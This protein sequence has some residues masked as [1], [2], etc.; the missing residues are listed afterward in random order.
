[1]KTR[2]KVQAEVRAALDAPNAD[3]RKIRYDYEAQAFNA[4]LNVIHGFDVDPPRSVISPAKQVQRFREAFWAM[5]MWSRPID[6]SIYHSGG[7]SWRPMDLISHLE[8]TI[9]RAQEFDLRDSFAR[10][11]RTEAVLYPIIAILAENHMADLKNGK[12]FDGAKV[13]SLLGV[14]VEDI[15]A[16]VTGKAAQ[17]KAAAPATAAA[18]TV[19]GASS[20]T[21]SAAGMFSGTA[22]AADD[23]VVRVTK[24]GLNVMAARP[25]NEPV[26]PDPSL[27][28]LAGHGNPPKPGGGH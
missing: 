11:G 7:M 15:V 12:C 5:E 26:N 24:E 18:T 2:E 8:Y 16:K 21:T 28:N 9:S 25:E 10:S 3:H 17:P 23:K 1:M 22:K 13:E 6:I 27:Y 4:I 19:A 14:S 20:A